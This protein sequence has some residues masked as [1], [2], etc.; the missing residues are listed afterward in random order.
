MSDIY[1]DVYLRALFDEM[2]S[3]YERVSTITSFGFN[4]RWRRQLSA[5]LDIRRGMQ[6]GDL[7]TGGGEMRAY[8]LPAIGER[9][10]LFAVDFTDEMVKQAWQRQ[11]QM[12]ARNMIVLH[13]DALCS[14][15]PSASLDVV[16]CAYGVKTLEHPHPF[17]QEISRILK[18]GG[19]FGLVEVSVPDCALLRVPY[20]FY[21]SIIV[22][23]IGRLL[24]GNPDNYRMLSVYTSEFGNCRE[25]ERCFADSGFA[26][27]YVEFFRGCATAV[28]GVK[29]VV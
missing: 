3:T 10:R 29:R 28:T 18:P 15:I 8:V 17:V 19:A 24:L 16:V 11:R 20:L 27:R 13:E 25:L 1:D 26:V 5:L 14:S 21:L 22:P 4:R 9:G 23:M 6:T 2:Q 12:G 7:M